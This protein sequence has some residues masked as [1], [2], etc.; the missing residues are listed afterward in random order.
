MGLFS[1]VCTECGA[2]VRKRALVCS[3]CG[4]AAPKGWWKCPACKKW[5]GND[6]NFCWNCNEPLHPESRKD[7]AGGVWHHPG[8]VI[9]QRFEVGDIRKLLKKGIKVQQGTSAILMDGGKY[10]DVIGPGEH[11]LESMA[12]K[13]NHWGSPP[14]RT[15]VLI[16]S[17]DLV[18]PLHLEGLR[19]SEQI[20]LELYTEILLRFKPKSA[21][22]FIENLL[23][24]NE[25]LTYD[26]LI[27]RVTG[28]I[29]HAVDAL[30]VGSTIEDLVQDPERRI[31]LEDSISQHA[32]E[33]L[34]RVGFEL[35]R[36]GSAEFVNEEYEAVR[37]R[38]SEFDLARRQAELD[39]RFRELATQDKMDQF[40]NEHELEE[41]AA[42]L[43]QERGL[44][45]EE[46]GHELNRLKQAHRHEI[47]IK[48]LQHDLDQEA[49]RRRQEFDLEMEEARKAL[50]LRAEK[51]EL[52][53]KNMAENAKIVEGK[54]LE[55]LIAI[56]DD[57]I[58]REQFMQLKKMEIEQGR[59][60]EELL[61]LA[62]A[63]SPEA[64]RALAEMS[65]AKRA[66]M[67]ESFRD[68]KKLSDENAASLERILTAALEAN[69]TVAGKATNVNIK[70]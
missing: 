70:K 47:E 21:K 13:V 5:V 41:Y 39:I 58:R 14:P 32:A 16:D 40:K 66:E 60:A 61:A 67:E 33:Y 50:K 25:K 64:A 2:K 69:A 38:M 49:K 55:T 37:D 26:E 34:K 28:E 30:C 10:K 15:A 12:R 48:E 22:E 36:I 8:D 51:E 54:N 18:I 56:T 44:S 63:N 29:R 1:D 23:K 20:P 52:K 31:R 65:K 7:I 62:A 42:A 19:S 9:A 57:P 6:S 35:V 3:S 11:N 4:K 45:T 43:A 17:G 68:R 53:R 24:D 46:R 59:S 27:T